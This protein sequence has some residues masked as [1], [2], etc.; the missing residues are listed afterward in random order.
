MHPSEL[1]EHEAMVEAFATATFDRQLSRFHERFG[2]IPLG[3]EPV[4]FRPEEPTP[5]PMAFQEI[6]ASITGDA[7][8]SPVLEFADVDSA[9]IFAILVL[10]RLGLSAEE[11]E[12]A[13]AGSGSFLRH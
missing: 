3:D 11:A 8:E 13:K 4:F 9:R 5:E 6:L 7:W 2:R 1:R 10:M 12:E